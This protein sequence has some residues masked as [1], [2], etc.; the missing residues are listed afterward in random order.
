MLL[1]LC[2]LIGALGALPRL[3]PPLTYSI[4]DAEPLWFGRSTRFA[5]AVL[6][7]N[8]RRTYQ[9]GHHGV[10]T[11][12]LGAL[13]MGFQRAASLEDTRLSLR[14]SELRTAFSSARRFVAI[15]SVVL[16]ALTVFL[17][18][19]AFTL[20]T[21][22]WAGV[23]MALDPWR[24]SLDRALHPDGML[25]GFVSVCLLAG[26]V[27]WHVNGG[28]SYLLLAAI[29]GGLAVTTK[30]PALVMLPPSILLLAAVGVWRDRTRRL[31]QFALELC[32]L[33][34]LGIGTALLSWPAL[35]VS[36]IWTATRVIRFAVE[37]GGRDDDPTGRFGGGTLWGEFSNYL[38]SI[39]FLVSPLVFLGLA[40]WAI[41]ILTRPLERRSAI[42]L[43]SLLIIG[44]ALAIVVVMNA[45]DKHSARYVAPAVS[46]F[47]VVAAIGFDRVAGGLRVARPVRLGGLAAFGIA[48]LYLCAA[49]RPYYSTYY[50]PLLGGPAAASDSMLLGR[51]VGLEPVSEFL[52]RL[53]EDPRPSI[54]APYF[55]IN[56]V[57]T[58]TRAT[59]VDTDLNMRT[60]YRLLYV[61][62]RQRGETPPVGPG[63][64]LVFTVNIGG[65]EYAR[66][67]RIRY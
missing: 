31:G 36:P 37:L 44:C 54:S 60:D 25:I 6:A 34:A 5:A 18:G 13:G 45:G 61:S 39:G 56:S 38:I 47:T 1:A 63:V 40:L 66:L 22:A 67:Y 2:L 8:A 4:A 46:L 30:S 52:N 50:S 42:G 41:W 59:V 21:A 35:L 64:E 33:G 53:P 12:W 57:R 9:A 51:G 65:V 43:Q 16:L 28:W 11:M 24:I 20:T 48:Q 55:L 49:E 17:I 26:L 32:T 7:G 15:G 23:L 62:A 14:S 29:A 3:S 58:Q 19:R 27:R 10:S